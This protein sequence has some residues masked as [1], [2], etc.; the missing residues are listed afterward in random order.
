MPPKNIST[1]AYWK[2]D[3]TDAPHKDVETDFETGETSK[4]ETPTKHK[5]VT[6]SDNL[7]DDL[8]TAPLEDTME[9]QS[10]DRQ[11]REQGL[12]NKERKEKLMTM[13]EDNL[14]DRNKKETSKKEEEEEEDGDD[15]EDKSLSKGKDKGKKV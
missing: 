4:P 11:W 8:V 2:E 5:K 3:P 14:R 12:S 7:E 1:G 13:L 6:T 9:A 15:D 10:L